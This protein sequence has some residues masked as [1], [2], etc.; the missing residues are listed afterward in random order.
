MKKLLIVLAVFSI[1]FTVE[2]QKKSKTSKETFMVDGICKMCKDRIEKVAMQTK[3][4][5]FASYDIDKKELYCIFNNK[6]T[7]V[8]ELKKA[9]AAAGHDTEEFKA[10]EKAY[11]A[12]DSCCYYRDETLEKH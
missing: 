11:L 9:M 12:L 3:G 10:T 2:A 1:S 6:K 5:K 4:V 8:T 7:S